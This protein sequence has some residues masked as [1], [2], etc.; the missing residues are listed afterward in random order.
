M[1]GTAQRRMRNRSTR[2]RR[3]LEEASRVYRPRKQTRGDRGG[4]RSSILH[5]NRLLARTPSTHFLRGLTFRVCCA[6]CEEGNV[7]RI[8]HQVPQSFFWGLKV[9]LTINGN[10]ARQ[11]NQRP[12]ARDGLPRC[13]AWTSVVSRPTERSTELHVLGDGG[14]AAVAVHFQTN[15]PRRSRRCA[16]TERGPKVGM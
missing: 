4:D 9:L 11:K 5:D 10:E 12:V 14:G 1:G 13:W 2:R 16:A 3:T 7:G 6:S 8:L 15:A